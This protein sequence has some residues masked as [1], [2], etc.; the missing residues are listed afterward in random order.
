MR[1]D[2]RDY[3]EDYEVFW[4]G[5][6]ENEDGTLNVDQ[7]KRELSD[8]I[9][10]MDNCA[11]AYCLMTD[12]AISKQNTLFSEVEGIFENIYMRRDTVVEDMYS[13]LKTDDINELKQNIMDYFYMEDLDES[14]N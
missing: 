10:V 13:L 1:R 9:M 6:I 12:Q 7:L 4:K 8:Y 5:I 14:R 2:S 3:L 11:L